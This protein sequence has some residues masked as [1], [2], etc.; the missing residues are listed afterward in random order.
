MLIIE[1]QTPREFEAYYF[2]RWQVLRQPWKKPEGSEKDEIERECIHAMVVDEN[3]NPLGVC[4]L[5]YN[6]QNTG[7]LRFMGVRNDM[8]G[9]GIGKMLL[10][11]LETKA[12]AAGRKTMILQAREN[13][14]KFYETSGYKIKEKTFLLWDEIQHYLMEKQLS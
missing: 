6:D 11:Y 9:K 8:Q 10:E 5:Q 7:Q 4:R 2:L 13:A 3:K 12:K 1:P 14:V